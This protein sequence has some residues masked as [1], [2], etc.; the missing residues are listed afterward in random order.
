MGRFVRVAVWLVVV[1]VVVAGL[2]WGGAALYRHRVYGTVVTDSQ[3]NVT[4]AVGD[5]FSLAV[6]DRGASV[7]DFWSAQPDTGNL[8]SPQGSRTRRSSLLDRVRAPLIGG[9]QGTTFF[10]YD[11]TAA[12]TTKVT[13]SNCFQGCD[14]PA[15]TAESRSITWTITV[16]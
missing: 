7:G 12:G 1:V 6:P 14:N 13:L 15:T 3:Q 10:L 4:V 9:G 5:R 2:V 16:G 8:L 11:A